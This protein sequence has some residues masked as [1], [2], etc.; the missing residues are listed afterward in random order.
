MVLEELN[1]HIGKKNQIMTPALHKIP[2][3]PQIKI[4]QRHKCGN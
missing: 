1:I 3:P 4:Y 2:S